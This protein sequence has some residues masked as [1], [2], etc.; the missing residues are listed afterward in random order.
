MEPPRQEANGGGPLSQPPGQLSARAPSPQP[1]V[2][3]VP[4]GG[5]GSAPGEGA[6]PSILSPLSLPTD[7]Q[8][9]PGGNRGR[10]PGGR[11]LDQKQGAG[12][13][14]A[15]IQG[16]TPPLC[17]MVPPPPSP[18]SKITPVLTKP[19]RI[20]SSRR[21][22]LGSFGGEGGEG[23]PLPA[24]VNKITLGETVTRAL[25]LYPAG[26]AGGSQS[27]PGS[28]VP[29]APAQGPAPLPALWL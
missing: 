28:F 14:C 29:R 11:N 7:V 23:C 22:G 18:S 10:S 4:G 2:G 16:R 26:R 6:S 1:G 20:L 19:S 8:Q 27:P 13:V 21:P 3:L 12:A 17:L 24:T 15:Q 9:P 5:G 25:I